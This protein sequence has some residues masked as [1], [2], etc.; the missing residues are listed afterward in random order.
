MGYKEENPD[1]ASAHER[2]EF[3]TKDTIW[4]HT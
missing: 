1:F 3:S 4:I 2:W